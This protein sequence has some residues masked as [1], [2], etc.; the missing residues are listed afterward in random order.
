MFLI[1]EAFLA[2]TT[3]R[4]TFRQPGDPRLGGGYYVSVI[5]RGVELDS[6]PGSHREGD[7]LDWIKTKSQAYLL[8]EARQ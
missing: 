5:K 1:A 6:V 2:L 8:A 4:I 3:G 7:A